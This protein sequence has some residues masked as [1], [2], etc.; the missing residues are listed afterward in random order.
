[1]F[2]YRDYSDLDTVE[3]QEIHCEPGNF[4]DDISHDI[5]N[6]LENRFDRLYLTDRFRRNR[7]SI[8]IVYP[9]IQYPGRKLLIK[10]PDHIRF[11]LSLY[12]NT[13][14]FDN[15]DKIVLRP[16]YI[17]I[18]DIELLALYLRSRK[19]L[20]LY[21]HHPF[22]YSIDSRF[23]E[24]TEFLPMTIT[25]LSSAKLFGN[26]A[27]NHGGGTKIPPLWYILS[28]V[29]HTP[30]TTIDKFFLKRSAGETR[31]NYQ[32]LTEIS[33]FYSQHGY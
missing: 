14:D 6:L 30:D 3:N 32:Y 18:G 8:D 1:M 19:I 20:V 25:R 21:L 15:I 22:F 31:S 5:D 17:E 2:D 9:R 4:E 29:M 7:N 33:F 26:P 12:P 10:G 23:S 16:R 13:G 28:M 27:E 24:Y 11:L